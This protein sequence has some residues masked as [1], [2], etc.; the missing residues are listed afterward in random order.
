MTFLSPDRLYL[1]VVVA[2]LAIAYVVMQM[3]RRRYIV[4][5]TNVDVVAEAAPR[6]PLWRRHATAAVFV[7]MLV[8]LVFAFARPVRSRRGA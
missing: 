8:A 3:R 7:V 1:F 5:F 2:L 4:L 6:N